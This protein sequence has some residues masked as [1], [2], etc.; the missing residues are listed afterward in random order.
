MGRRHG[1]IH[2]R[3]ATAAVVMVIATV[4]CTELGCD[5][6]GTRWWTGWIGPRE[7]HIV[8]IDD[9]APQHVEE[10]G[11]DPHITL[12][13]AGDGYASWRGADNS[14]DPRAITH[15]GGQCR[16]GA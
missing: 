3:L 12:H 14:F 10:C 5:C 11:C 15:K 8:P 7:I 9:L 6:P 2:R 16:G 4:H 1:S 13:V